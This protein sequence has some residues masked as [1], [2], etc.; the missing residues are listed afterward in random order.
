[1]SITYRSFGTKDFFPTLDFYNKYGKY[2]EVTTRMWKRLILL[3]PNFNSNWFIIAEEDNK[4]IVGLVYV[5]KRHVPIDVGATLEEEKAWINAFAVKP[6]YL[7]TIGNEL[8]TKAEK[9][10][11]DSNAKKLIA[12]SYTP[13]YFSQGIDCVHYREYCK[14]FDEKGYSHGEESHSM[15]MDLNAFEYSETTRRIKENLAKEGI[16]FQH[17][18][19]EYLLAFFNYLQQYTKPGW[20]CRLRKLLLDTEDLGRVHIALCGDKV[21][22]FNMYGDPDTSLNRYGPYGVAYDYRGK[23]IGKVLL[24]ECLSHMKESG[25]NYAWMQ[26]AS[27]DVAP[28]MYEKIGFKASGSY[29][30]YEKELIH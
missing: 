29:L 4:E 3:D 22:G 19:E 20:T 6:E 18:T 1:M 2:E 8:I 26:W 27:G 5:I 7:D 11:I 28:H 13:N 21:I 15:R 24:E 16:T 30:I 14:L 12:T 25:L 23:K 17:L 9:L 10:A